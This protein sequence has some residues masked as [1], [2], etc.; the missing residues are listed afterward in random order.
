[1]GAAGPNAVLV[2]ASGG[3]SVGVGDGDGSG[4]GVAVITGEGSGVGVGAAVAVSA[5]G[6]AVGDAGTGAAVA[7]GAGCGVGAGVAAGDPTLKGVLTAMVDRAWVAVGGMAVGVAVAAAG[8][9]AGV[10]P[11][12]DGCGATLGAGVQAAS[13][14]RLQIT[15]R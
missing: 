10:T 14:A 9:E 6:A 2:K 7:V 11:S 8:G 15:K 13:S 5:D 1:M 12:G 4:A 3:R